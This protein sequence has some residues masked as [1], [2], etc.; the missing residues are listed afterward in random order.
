MALC[1]YTRIF[2][3]LH[4]YC[5]RTQ[6]LYF[7][8]RE[9]HTQK[10]TRKHKQGLEAENSK[11]C[12]GKKSKGTTATA[13]NAEARLDKENQTGVKI[14]TDRGRKQMDLRNNE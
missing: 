14:Q 12:A 8:M 10:K 9:I 4:G 11:H 1:T 7:I 6:V 5:S 3:A 13:N 2:R